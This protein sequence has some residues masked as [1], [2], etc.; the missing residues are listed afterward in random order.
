[1][2]ET[3]PDIIGVTHRY[4]EVSGIRLHV[5][6]AGKGKPLL[7]LHGW[8][9]HWYV[10]RK[11]IPLLSDKYQL[12][13]PDLPGF[14]W[15]DMPKDNDFQKEKLAGTMIELLDKLNLKKVGLIGHDWGGWIGFLACLQRPERFSKYL[16]LGITHPFKKFHLS[17]FQYRRFMY[18]LPIA[19]LGEWLFSN[20]PSL[21]EWSIKKCTY[22]KDAWTK[23][24][25]HIFSHALQDPERAKASSLMYRTF[26]TKELL[27]IFLGKYKTQKPQVPTHLLIGKNDPIIHPSLFLKNNIENIKIEIVENCGHF[28]AEEQP[29]FVTGKI[30]K[31]FTDL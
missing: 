6:I 24:D 16:A 15:S 8:P 1:M 22:K 11:L 18:Q 31:F 30:S 10:W 5:A 28:I 9:Q 25:L 3:F 19:M 7:L 21:T 20:L 12:I 26:L 23:E 17:I 29:E 4:I 27:P 14:G 13:M 2:K